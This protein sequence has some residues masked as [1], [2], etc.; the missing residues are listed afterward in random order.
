MNYDVDAPLNIHTANDGEIYTVHDDR[1][2]YQCIRRSER[3]DTTRYRPHSANTLHVPQI[4]GVSLRNNT[5]RLSRGRR[6]RE[7]SLDYARHGINEPVDVKFHLQL[8]ATQMYI[9]RRKKS[10]PTLAINQFPGK[11]NSSIRAKLCIEASPTLFP[12]RYPTMTSSRG[13]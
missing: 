8:K 1:L 7:Q 2:H 3:D 12:R 11:Q 4:I 6:T 13:N 10:Q 9:F 5:W